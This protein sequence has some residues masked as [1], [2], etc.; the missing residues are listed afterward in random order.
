MQGEWFIHCVIC[1]SSLCQLITWEILPSQGGHSA[2]PCMPTPSHPTHWGKHTKVCPWMVFSRFLATKA[3]LL[4]WFFSRLLWRYCVIY[5][6]PFIALYQPMW[7]T[8]SFLLLSFIFYFCGCFDIFI[9]YVRL[10]K[11]L[12][13]VSV[14]NRFT[15]MALLPRQ[16]WSKRVETKIIAS[17]KLKGIN[18]KA[19]W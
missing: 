14:N 1:S 17:Y 16:N 3:M 4:L 5:L 8:F 6:M 18:K 13:H 10:F 7:C 19:S 12:Q 11:T 9:A 2:L 15:K